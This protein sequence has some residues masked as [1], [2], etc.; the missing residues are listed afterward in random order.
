MNVDVDQLLE[1]KNPEPARLYRDAVSRLLVAKIRV[2]GGQVRD[3]QE[4]EAARRQLGES[5]RQTIGVAEILGAQEAL[6][7]A[8]AA[9]ARGVRFGAERG[10]L[11]AFAEQTLIPRV[12]FEEALEDFVTRAPVTILDAAERTAA[13][14]S[15]LYSEGR[16]LAFVRSAEQAVT[17][18]AASFLADAFA[19]GLGEREAARGLRLAVDSV[20]QATEAWSESYARTVFRTNLNTAQT[21]GKFRQASDPVIKA[22]LPAARFSAVGDRD[23]RPNHGAADGLILATDNPAWGQL[24]PPLG[25]NCRCKVRLI[26]TPELQDRGRLTEDFEIVES[27]VPG[28]AGPDPGFRH[29]GRPDLAGVPT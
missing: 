27:A 24:A 2:D 21:A 3:D 12:T 8:S 19:E 28:N 25:Y 13:R 22:V 6:Q 29:A 18:R 20:R 23:T 11:L 14:I 5:I 1:T 17:D 15:E 16:V 26:S 4:V 10:R 7:Q 9:Y